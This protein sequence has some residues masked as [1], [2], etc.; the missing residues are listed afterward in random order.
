MRYEAICMRRD[1]SVLTPFWY[2]GF[3]NWLVTCGYRPC[4]APEEELPGGGLQYVLRL[5]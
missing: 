1:I 5:E 4:R 2:S 3:G